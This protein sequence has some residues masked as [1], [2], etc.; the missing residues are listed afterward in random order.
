[1]RKLKLLFKVLTIVI[2]LALLAVTALVLT[3]DPNNYKD[4]ITEQVEA[5]TG[6]EFTIAGDIGLSVFPWVG[7]EVEDVQL[8]NAEGFSDRA[9]AKIAQLDVKVKVLP[10]LRKQLEDMA[11]GGV[12]AITIPR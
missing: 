12:Y 4:T 10:L 5:Q 6:R 11:D 9:F 7:V 3:F 1:M 8:A 2:A